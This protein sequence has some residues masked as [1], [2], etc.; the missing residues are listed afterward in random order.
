M[1]SA[2][3]SRRGLLGEAAQLHRRR[4]HRLVEPVPVDLHAEAAAGQPR[5]CW[6]FRPVIPANL[7][8]AGMT[9]DKWYMSVKEAAAMLGMST[10]TVKVWCRDGKI[11]A[12]Q[13]T[14]NGDWMIDRLRFI[15]D[16]SPDEI[17]SITQ[18]RQS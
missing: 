16:Y 10:S 15:K 1:I 9:R 14:P 2:T 6:A 17:D 8:E 3:P 13:F 4:L 11:R 5:N 7:Q 12:R 18:N